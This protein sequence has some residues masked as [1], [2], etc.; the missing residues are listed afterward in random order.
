MS[1]VQRLVQPLTSITGR[2]P[3]LH[4]TLRRAY[5]TLPPSIRGRRMVFDHLR[6]VVQ[7]RTDQTF[8]LIGANDG[9][10]ADH[11]F[12]FVQ[13]YRWRGAA[14]E[15]VPRFFQA[16]QRNY[17]GLPV[18]L[19]NVAVHHEARSMPLYYIDADTG[20]GLPPWVRG[21]GSFDREQ[22]L[23]STRA[24]GD[25]TDAVRS[26]DVPCRT[27]DEVV[28]E[29]GLPRVDIIVIDVEGYDHEVVRRIRFDAW[30]TH[31]VIVEYSHMSPHILHD[32]KDL[33]QRQGF[34]LE[35]DHEDLLAWRIVN[36]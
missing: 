32:V 28:Q 6:A 24:L 23:E 13:R 18:K 30:K 9:Y 27:I 5:R 16:L 14:V 34:T 20:H 4:R 31:T 15:P 11:L 19:L 7:R 22:V 33:L 17:Q 1:F 21:V 10:M 36:A 35:Q 26:V 25:L 2:F 3:A 12:D 8:L 29:S